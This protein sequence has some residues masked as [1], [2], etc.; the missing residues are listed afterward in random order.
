MT[1][2]IPLSPSLFL[3]RI[4]RLRRGKEAFPLEKIQGYPSNDT[5]LPRADPSQTRRPLA[6]SS[7]PLRRLTFQFLIDRAAPRVSI[8]VSQR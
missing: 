6:E 7:P 2:R 4:S 8:R 3:S 1:G 5:Y